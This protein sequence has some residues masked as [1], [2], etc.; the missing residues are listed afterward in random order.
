MGRDKI[1]LK[2]SG[3]NTQREH[4]ETLSGFENVIDITSQEYFLSF[5]LFVPFAMRNI[6][7]GVKRLIIKTVLVHVRFRVWFFRLALD[8]LQ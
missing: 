8:C 7:R 2:I 3:R 5:S 1:E 6:V 4:R